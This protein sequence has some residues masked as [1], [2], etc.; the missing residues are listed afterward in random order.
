[1][2]ISRLFGIRDRDRVLQLLFDEES[3][4]SSSH[5]SSYSVL[6]H[7]IPSLPPMNG[8][9]NPRIV[10]WNCRFAPKQEGRI[11]KFKCPVRVNPLFRAD[12]LTRF[13]TRQL[14]KNVQGTIKNL[15]KRVQLANQCQYMIFKISCRTV[16]LITR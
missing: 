5:N 13:R 7:T 12:F 1:M 8:L 6:V 11:P 16:N 2:V 4:T 3:L 9:V 14:C 10:V 15:T